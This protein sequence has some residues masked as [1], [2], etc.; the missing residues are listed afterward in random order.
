M[1]TALILFPS[2]ARSKLHAT[3]YEPELQCIVVGQCMNVM[4]NICSQWLVE[5]N[6]V[7]MKVCVREMRKGLLSCGAG[8]RRDL[9]S[10]SI[11]PG[12]A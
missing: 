11:R 3:H 10:R 1:K 4:Q 5:K 8:A 6:L 2:L 7:E 9:G 12:H